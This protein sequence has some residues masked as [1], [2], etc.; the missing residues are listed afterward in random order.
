MH[1]CRMEMM[2]AQSIKKLLD[3]FK[4]MGIGMRPDIYGERAMPTKAAQEIFS[5]AASRKCS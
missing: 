3:L 4:A 5:A 2:V 1:R